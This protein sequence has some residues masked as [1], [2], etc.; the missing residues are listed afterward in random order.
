MPDELKS[1]DV[2]SKLVDALRLDLVGP[3][4]TLGEAK[5]ALPQSPSRWY[6][7]GFLVPLDAAP[8]DKTDETAADDLDEAGET[9]G[10]DDDDPPEKPAARARYFP[11]SIGISVLVPA[12]AKT[13]TVHALWGDYRLRTEPPEQWERTP[14]QEPVAIELVKASERPVEKDVPNSNG[15]KIAY[16]ARAVGKLAAD[17][18]VPADARTV[19]VFLVNRRTPQPDVKKDEAF[20]FQVQLEITGDT[21]FCLARIYAVSPAGSGTN[22]CQTFNTG[23]LANTLLVTTSQRML[24]STGR[25]AAMLFEPVGFRRQK[26]SAWNLH[27]SKMSSCEW[28]H[29]QL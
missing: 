18:G 27:R 7:T 21:D 24:F 16:L 10:V 20:A 13:L 17:A 1:V 12:S 19:S 28:M 5:E 9:G 29:L 14:R 25:N 26:W 2:R 23:I 3:S 11:S 6:L 15:L 22:V 4:E 8:E